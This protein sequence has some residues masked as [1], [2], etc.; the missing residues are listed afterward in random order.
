[1]LTKII[2]VSKYLHSTV[3]WS[4]HVLSNLFLKNNPAAATTKTKKQTNKQTHQ[5]LRVLA[6]DYTRHSKGKYSGR[7]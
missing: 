2:L 6:M 5:I 4:L 7:R 3:L 1:V